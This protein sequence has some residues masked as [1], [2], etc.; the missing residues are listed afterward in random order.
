MEKI[1]NDIKFNCPSCKQPLE[2]SIDM[3]GQ[4]ID[5]P[6]CK[7]V[8]EVP[9]QIILPKSG[10]RI[11]PPSRTPLPRPIPPPA[12]MN[13]SMPSATVNSL[14]KILTVL[15]VIAIMVGTYFIYNFWKDQQRTKAEAEKA[16]IEAI[17]AEAK[18][19]AEAPF[20]LAA[21]EALD[22]AH[23]IESAVSIGISYQKYGGELILVAAKVDNLLRAASETGIE[24]MRPEAKMFC[25]HII[26]ARQDFKIAR[27]LWE[28]QI[29]FP[30]LDHTAAK[31]GMHNR[32]IS[33]SD[34]LAEA[35]T[36]F[37]RLKNQ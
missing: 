16:R 26:N 22:Q 21:K 33:A 36:I 17:K 11:P 10:G 23:K 7:N 29:K 4:L 19:K 14:P 3:A 2:A 8:L 9:E 27:I 37:I 30:D 24:N 12:Q 20:F 1:V 35:D 18:A 31:E 25:E 28:S 5:C 6:A 13:D 34:S 15:V 32:W